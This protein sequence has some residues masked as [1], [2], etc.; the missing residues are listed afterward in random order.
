LNVGVRLVAASDTRYFEIYLTDTLENG[1]GYC[2][3]L[4]E[5]STF[6][7]LILKPLMPGGSAFH[8]LVKHGEE[9]DS[10][11]Y[12]CLRDYGNAGEHAL[13]D[14]R[15]GLDLLQI[16][17]AP[18]PS[19]PDLN[20][21]WDSVVSL[22]GHSLQ[23]ALSGSAL[24]YASGLT[25]VVHDNSLRCVLTHPFWPLYHEAA[26]HLADQVGVSVNRLPLA[27]VFDAVRRLGSIVSRPSRYLPMWD[28]KRQMSAVDRKSTREAVT[29][30]DLPEKLPHRGNFEL[31]LTDD[32]LGRIAGEGATLTFTK[33]RK[34]TKPDDLRSKIVIVQDPDDASKALIGKLH[35][36]PMQD[37][38]G[39][40]SQIKIALRPQSKGN[41][42]SHRWTIAVDQWPSAIYVMACLAD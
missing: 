26:W 39:R 31:L 19:A 22:A 4:G 18:V 42:N 30:S 38:D 40:L 29:L 14:W 5:P 23:K 28:M 13:L 37:S 32:R 17:V 6:E 21:Y 27:N 24:K 41:Y 16:A 35:L 33:L 2:A 11:C 36:Q 3:H 7:E 8:R 20:G 10:S 34:D 15:L 12:D 25:C 1:A 9:C